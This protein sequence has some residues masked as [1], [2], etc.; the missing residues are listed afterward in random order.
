MTVRTTTEPRPAEVW[1]TQQRLVLAA[2]SLAALMAVLNGT[3]V[4]AALEALAPELGTSISGVVWVTTVY[5][6]AASV[7]VPLVGWLTDRWGSTRVLQVGLVGFVAGSVLSGFAWDLPSMVVFRFVQGLAGGMLEPASLAIVG[8]IAP[9]PRLGRVMGLMSLVI[10]AGPVVGPLVGSA[11]VAAEQWRWIFWVNVPL[12]LVTGVVAWRLLPRVRGTAAGAGV[13]VVGLLL[14]PPGFVLVLLGLNRWGVGAPPGL[15][16]VLVALGA[17][18]LTA[19]VAHARRHARP[20]LDVGLLRIRA[21]AAALAVMSTV[22]LTMYTQ[23]TVLPVV[24]VRDLG[25]GA[26]WAGLPVAVLGVGLMVSMTLGGRASDAL[27]TR[28]LVVGGASVTAVAAVTV[29]LVRQVWPVPALLAVLL[30]LGLGFGCVA[31]P[32]F[33]SVYRV[34]PEASIAQ[35]TAALFIVVQLFAS[36]GVTIVGFLTATAS[37]PGG[38]AYVVVAA[39]AVVAVALSRLLPGRPTA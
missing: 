18:L 33:A 16:S 9:K 2:M 24:A 28:V 1:G 15:V 26:A 23:L 38:V 4:T 25:L 12:G 13:D 29:V 32:S 30:V 3:T 20:L 14:L 34:L 39:L 5:L 37:D 11:L 35:G 6:V 7:S 17:A 8:A 36:A 27:G 22:G 31:A 21:F 19:Y 10:N